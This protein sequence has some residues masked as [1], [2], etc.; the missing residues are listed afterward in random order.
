MKKNIVI[1]LFLFV[2]FV[3]LSC[4]KPEPAPPVESLNDV[5]NLIKDSGI[6]VSEIKKEDPLVMNENCNPIDFINFDVEDKW[7]EV[8]MYEDTQK[9]EEGKDKYYAQLMTLA[10][11]FGD[12][13]EGKEYRKLADELLYVKGKFFIVLPE[14]P[15]Q[16][17]IKPLLDKRL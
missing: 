2:L 13:K 10:E 17:K 14:T 15:V 4:S 3:F 8:L 1:T 5:Y 7:I 16:E 12:S 9:A 11:M 6:A